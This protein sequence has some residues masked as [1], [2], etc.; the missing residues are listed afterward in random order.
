MT[1]ANGR[2]RTSADGSKFYD[3]GS[4]GGGK[5]G[6]EIGIGHELDYA[7]DDPVP[8]LK[9]CIGNHA[10][11]W[12][13]PL[14]SADG[15]GAKGQSYQGHNENPE[16]KPL[17]GKRWYAGLQYD[18]STY[19]AKQALKNIGNQDPGATDH[20]VAGFFWWQEDAISHN[21]GNGMARMM[22]V[23]LQK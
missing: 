4:G 14:P 17:T 19:Y 20:E 15:T 3:A 8:L 13:F 16:R 21:G 23:L 18:G 2:T 6:V 11:G 7:P 10:L 5:S 1:G 9:I 12:D 22:A